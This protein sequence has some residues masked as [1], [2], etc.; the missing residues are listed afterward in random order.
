LVAQSGP[1]HSGSHAHV[2]PRVQM[3]RLLQSP[4]CPDEPAPKIIIEWPSNDNRRVTT[5]IQQPLARWLLWLSPLGARH[6]GTVGHLI[7]GGDHCAVLACE[8]RLAHARRHRPLRREGKYFGAT[9]VSSA[10]IH[11]VAMESAIP[12]HRCTRR[13]SSLRSVSHRAAGGSHA[14]ASTSLP[15]R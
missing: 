1:P 8:A 14:H 4:T 3:P 15:H 13:G 10:R 11:P 7:A 12:L 5:P 9:A 2:P 6:C